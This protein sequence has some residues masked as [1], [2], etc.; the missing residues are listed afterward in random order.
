MRATM[1]P[2]G[3]NCFFSVSRNDGTHVFSKT[4]AQHERAV[5]KFQR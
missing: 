2:D 4:R 1:N 5:D 3:S